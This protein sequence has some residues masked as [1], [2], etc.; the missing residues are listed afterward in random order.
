MWMIHVALSL[1]VLRDSGGLLDVRKRQINDYVTL[2]DLEGS[3]HVQHTITIVIASHGRRHR[4]EATHSSDKRRR[5]GN[6]SERN[7]Y[8]QG[9]LDDIAGTY[10]S[11]HIS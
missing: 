1:N 7:R 3:L 9:T 4:C 11:P 10:F 6:I 5:E 8:L 2:V